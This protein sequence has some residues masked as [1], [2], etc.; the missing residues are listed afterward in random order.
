[1][2]VFNE[3][4]IAQLEHYDKHDMVQFVFLCTRI[5][6][7]LNIKSIEAWKH[8][9]DHGRD[10]IESKMDETLYF[11]LKVAFT[12]KFM[13][14]GKRGAKIRVL[15]SHTANAFHR[16]LHAMV[17]IIKKLLDMGFD[18]VL[19]GKNIFRSFRGRAWYL[20]LIIW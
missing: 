17:Y 9:N 2:N 13:H 7:I 18:Y 14:S 5:W 10:K 1:M 19:P 6:K 12:I 15:T 11:L 20:P 8:S 16:T 4:F 3:K